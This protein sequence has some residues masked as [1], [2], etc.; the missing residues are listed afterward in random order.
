MSYEYA[1]RVGKRSNASNR[2][3]IIRLHSFWYK[4]EVLRCCQNTAYVN[5]DTEPNYLVKDSIEKV[6][7]AYMNLYEKDIECH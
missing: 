1:R 7:T 2:K 4:N 6:H 3:I 5:F